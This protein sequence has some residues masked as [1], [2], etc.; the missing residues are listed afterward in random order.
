MLGR[1]LARSSIVG[2]GLAE[3]DQINNRRINEIESNKTNK[4]NELL[5]TYKMNLGNID[6]NIAG[7]NTEAQNGINSLM[8]NRENL[9]AQLARQLE[10]DAWDKQYKERQ[11]QAQIA[12]QNATAGNKSSGG[13]SSY[14]SKNNQ[15]SI[16]EIINSN[17]DDIAKI[18]T[19]QDMYKEFSSNGDKKSSDL[20]YS[21]LLK[22]QNGNKKKQ[23]L[24]N[25]KQYRLL[26]SSGLF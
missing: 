10:N 8:S 15:S 18:R 23:E 6:A 12:Y 22:L 4:L 25:D 17:A 20:A 19:L 24:S 14:T 7:A 13:V 26:K 11:L 1:G 5:G 21:E 2:T 16:R 3:A 9:I